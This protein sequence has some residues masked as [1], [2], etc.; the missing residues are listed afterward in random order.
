M[1]SIMVKEL[2]ATPGGIKMIG[3]AP[4]LVKQLSYVSDPGVLLSGKI[5][6]AGPIFKQIVY[7]RLCLVI[8]LNK[9]STKI[10]FCKILNR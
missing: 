3:I 9:I 5:F 6:I 1:W 7:M 8:Q 4:Q 2:S 10:T